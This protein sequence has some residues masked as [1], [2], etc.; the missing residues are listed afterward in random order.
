L[1]DF[2][3]KLGGADQ[4]KLEVRVVET[5][6]QIRVAVH[7][8]DPELRT[9]LQQGLGDLV[10]KLENHGLRA[11]TWTPDKNS[12]NPNQQSPGDGS[13]GRQSRDQQEAPP[14]RR[15][16]PAWVDEGA[17]AAIQSDISRRTA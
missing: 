7:S 16:K 17:F 8:P 10:G 15:I 2:S 3:L 11:E 5:A 9:S 13:Q 12:Q 14:R 6:G 1:R 4:D